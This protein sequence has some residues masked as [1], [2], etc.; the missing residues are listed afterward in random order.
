MDGK[1]NTHEAYGEYKTVNHYTQRFGM[2]IH[3]ELDES[4]SYGLGIS[5]EDNQS[6]GYDGRWIATGNTQHLGF[7]LK[8]QSGST[9]VALIQTYSWSQADVERV[10]QLTDAFNTKVN[11]QLETHGGRLRLSDVVDEGSSTVRPAIAL[12]APHSLA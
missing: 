9:Q 4:W 7:E 10:G 2:G 3:Q 8:H 5:Y 11:R 6:D 12:G 1:N